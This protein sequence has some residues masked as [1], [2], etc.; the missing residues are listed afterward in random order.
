MVKMLYSFPDQHLA[1]RLGYTV[2]RLPQHH[3]VNTITDIENVYFNS[4][5]LHVFA[6]WEN[7]GA[8]EGTC[9]HGIYTER[10]TDKIPTYTLLV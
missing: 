7:T 8:V 5:N 9:E 1:G 3:R 4:P 10:T 6:L 2:D